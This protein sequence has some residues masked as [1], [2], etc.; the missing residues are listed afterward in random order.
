MFPRLDDGQIE[1]IARCGRR[2]RVDAGEV[3]FEAGE[4]NTRFF[5]V[6]SGALAVSRP[7]ETGT[8]EL[9]RLHEPGEFTGEV[10][11]LLGRRS[12]VRGQMRQAGEVVEV[13]RERVRELVA[14]DP[15][16][17]DILMCAFI[18][19]RAM[20]IERE[21]GDVVIVGSRHSGDTLQLREFL[22]RNGHP[23]AYLDVETHEGVKELLARFGVGVDEIP[24]VILRGRTVLRNP[25]N[26]EL[27]RL[28]GLSLELDD[29]TVRDVIV[30]GAGPA[31]LA[32]AVYAASEGLDVLVL[33]AEAPG[34]QAG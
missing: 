23:H 15:V 17:S 3:L 13:P 32:A 33:E 12:V 10:D 25:S 34:G 5:V 26:R 18:L 7:T 4:R 19:R 1:R 11:V 29:R 28:L 21:K 27:A 24:I 6:V 16:L 30:V 8:E 20:L 14:I 2:R 31:G 22:T 9:I